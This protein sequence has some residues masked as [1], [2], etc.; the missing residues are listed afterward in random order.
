MSKIVDK[1]DTASRLAELARAPDMPLD[2]TIVHALDDWEI[3]WREGRGNFEKVLQAVGTRG[4]D[5]RVEGIGEAGER[6][7]EREN[8]D[9][10]ELQAGG[11]K[12]I[13]RW[14]RVARGG[15]NRVASGEPLKVAVLRVLDGD[16]N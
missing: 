11:G 15:H 2:L 10:Q 5:V 9:Y 12:K 7:G 4:D 6:E 16:V 13:V 8:V 14:E 1:W 3:P